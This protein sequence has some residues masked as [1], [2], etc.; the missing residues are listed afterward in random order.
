MA[1]RLPTAP[2]RTPHARYAADSDHNLPRSR[3]M[4]TGGH[5][6]VEERESREAADLTGG[7]YAGPSDRPRHAPVSYRL[8]PMTEEKRFPV[9]E[10]GVVSRKDVKM[11]HTVRHHG[12]IGLFTEA[13]VP[14]VKPSGHD[15][16]PTMPSVSSAP[17]LHTP[18][19]K[20]PR[21]LQKGLHAPATKRCFGAIAMEQHG[22]KNI[23]TVFRG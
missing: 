16:H 9:K 23:P 8:A 4:R 15:V 12:D 3:G 17:M 2:T 22:K 6:N 18:M 7:T 11:P 21:D 10:A 5:L 14:L 19:P 1:M 20:V 13:T